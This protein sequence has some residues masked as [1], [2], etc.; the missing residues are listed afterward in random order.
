MTMDSNVVKFPSNA[1]RRTDFL[2]QRAAVQDQAPS[3]SYPKR[4][5]RNPLRIHLNMLS[6][7]E[8]DAIRQTVRQLLEEEGLK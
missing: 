2:E 5:K 3:A 8:V 7:A 6:I 1:S 4:S